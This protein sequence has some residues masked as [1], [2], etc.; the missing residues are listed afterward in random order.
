[1]LS[2]MTSVTGPRFHELAEASRTLSVEEDGIQHT[3]TEV[4]KVVRNIWPC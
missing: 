2:D 3:Y 4:T 1:M